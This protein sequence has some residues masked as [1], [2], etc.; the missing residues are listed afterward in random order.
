MVDFG[1]PHFTVHT[2]S[3]LTLA[4]IKAYKGGA[5]IGMLP[6]AQ[7]AKPTAGLNQTWGRVLQPLCY[8]QDSN[9]AVAVMAQQSFKGLPIN[10]EYSPDEADLRMTKAI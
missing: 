6:C 4:W 8:P 2:R 9:S 5:L 7:L 10:I 1:E 3:R